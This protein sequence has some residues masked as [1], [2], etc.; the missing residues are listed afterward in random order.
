MG[1]AA[2]L[3][4]GHQSFDAV[5]IDPPYYD[6]VP[7]ADLSD[8]FYVWLRRTVG[9]LY[10]EAFRTELTP[11]DEEA[12]VNPARFGGGKRGEQIAEAHYRRLMQASFAEIHRVLKPEGLCVVMFTHRSTAAWE[13]LIGSLLDAGLYPTASFPVHTEMEASTHQHGKGAIRSTILMA[14]RRRP[15]DAGVG[16][17]PQVRGELHRVIPERLREF[18]AAG[19]RGA[20]FFISAIG[21][22][23]GVFGRYRQVMR[24]DG[25]VVTIA[26]LLD[27]TRSIVTEFALRQL[28]LA[29]LDLPTRFYVLY[30]WAYGGER[31]AF[32]DANKLAKGIGVE[33]DE[34][35]RTHGL[36][37]RQGNEVRVPI[38]AE[39][40]EEAALQRMERALEAGEA[41]SRW[42]IDQV[43][44]ALW[45]WG[46]G[47][48]E[49]L[50]KYL[51]TLGVTNEDH[52]FWRTA[53][54]LLEVEQAQ[55]NGALEKEVRA[56]SQLLGSKQ[57]LLREA[58]TLHESGRQL[59]FEF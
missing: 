6:N 26:E 50:S 2:S 4:F 45:W 3:P 12:V 54:A 31:L 13:S 17:Y 58:T 48:R 15:E 56:L 8:F 7:Y 5:V 39:R 33:L 41:P 9:D 55:P 53:Q 40:F 19:I 24:P 27:E 25:T 42:T 21:P 23:V 43:H 35:A 34:L 30:R 49:T 38:F 47:E 57:G 51:A 36:V 20:D 32:D 44:L 14:C 52:P 37:R 18:W 11:K 10:P 29:A 1:S 16:W 46:K 59:R 28:G 22:A